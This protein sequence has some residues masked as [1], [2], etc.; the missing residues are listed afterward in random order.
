VHRE[1]PKNLPIHSKTCHNKSSKEKKKTVDLDEI[2]VIGMP[3]QPTHV[4]DTSSSKFEIP[5]QYLL[6]QN[7]ALIKVGSLRNI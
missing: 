4:I 5:L 2:N 1:Q 3:V 6:A 7:Q